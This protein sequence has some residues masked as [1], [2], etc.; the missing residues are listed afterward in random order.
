M[1]KH[2]QCKECLKEGIENPN[3]YLVAF[4]LCWR[5][6]EKFRKTPEYE[7]WQKSKE[8]HRYLKKAVKAIG[9]Q[10][11]N[12]ENVI[13]KHP[14]ILLIFK[15]F[16]ESLYNTIV[17]EAHFQRRSVQDE[18]LHTLDIHYHTFQGDDE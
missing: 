9:K 5:H 14:T 4:D 8:G 2:G 10:T 13:N 15:N 6:Y 17:N 12:R 16:D 18:I 11:E 7:V 3:K 1:A